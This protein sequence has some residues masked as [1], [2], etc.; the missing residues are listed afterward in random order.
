MAYIPC[1]F[2]EK[3]RVCTF[4]PED[5]LPGKCDF[6]GLE[7]TVPALE[8]RMREEAE[9]IEALRHRKPMDT[10]LIR[11]KGTGILLMRR[12]WTSIRRRS[13]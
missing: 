13:Q 12:I 9:A 3:H 4:K 2:R 11:D 8:T 10:K 6:Y 7:C 1:A 5:C